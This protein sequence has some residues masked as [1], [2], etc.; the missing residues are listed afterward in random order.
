L[1]FFPTAA[2]PARF[3]FP[4][5]LIWRDLQ[6]RLISC[7]PKHDETPFERGELQMQMKTLLAAVPLCAGLVFA[8][9]PATD[10]TGQSGNSTSQSATTPQDTNRT[11]AQTGDM[12][13]SSAGKS[14]SGILVASG[15]NS[16][17]M[18]GAWSSSSL[19]SGVSNVGS[20]ERATTGSP[21]SDLSRPD[22]QSANKTEGSTTGDISAKDTTAANQNVDQSG[23]M[24]RGTQPGDISRNTVGDKSVNNPQTGMADRERGGGTSANTGSQ[25]DRNSGSGQSWESGA[26]NTGQWDKA[27]FIS[28]T[29]TSFVFLT[30]DGKQVRL[31][32]ASNSMVQ[33]RLSSTNRVQEKSKIFRVRLTGD[34]TGDTV[35]ITDI[36]I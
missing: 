11:T 21:A 36:Q 18:N 27:C 23:S 31:D 1:K 7:S 24:P 26:S 12:N 34:V 10:T 28:P 9:T 8:Q 22:A 14:M 32:D 20:A 13:R 4:I 16:S 29:T 6:F 35:H 25:M 17:S 15:C 5:W 19:G 33:Q 3:S 30:K 2:A